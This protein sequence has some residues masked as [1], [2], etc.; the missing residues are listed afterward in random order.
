MDFVSE[1]LTIEN[2]LVRKKGM[3]QTE[4]HSSTY[5]TRNNVNGSGLRDNKNND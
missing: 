2:V 5:I 1:T 4:A 3:N